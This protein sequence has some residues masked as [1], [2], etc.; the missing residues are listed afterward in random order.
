MIMSATSLMDTMSEM[1]KLLKEPSEH[2]SKRLRRQVQE[3]LSLAPSKRDLKRRARQNFRQLKGAHGWDRDA[4][5]G[6]FLT[7]HLAGADGIE[8]VV[9]AA[10][11]FLCVLL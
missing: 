10:Q 3:D 5:R 8:G 1:K 7:A 9:E 11:V 6:Q 2:Y 4:E